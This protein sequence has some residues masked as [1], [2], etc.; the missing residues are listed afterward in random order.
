MRRWPGRAIGAPALERQP[1]GVREQVPERRAGRPGRLVE[2]DEPLLRGDEH[3][4][5]GR[6]LRHRR[7][8][9]AAARV[10]ARRLDRAGHADGD[11]LAR[12]SVDLAQRLHERRD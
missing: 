9:E 4:D 3:R 11:V 7:P 12:P 1:G 10:A 6:E 5:R 8:R 2:V